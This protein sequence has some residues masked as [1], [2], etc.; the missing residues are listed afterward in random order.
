MSTNIAHCTCHSLAGFE[1]DPGAAIGIV[2]VLSLV[3]G[4]AIVFVS[5]FMAHLVESAQELHRR[6]VLRHPWVIVFVSMAAL[7]GAFEYRGQTW[8][9]VLAAGGSLLG[10]AVMLRAGTSWFRWTVMPSAMIMLALAGGIR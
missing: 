2:A 6:G 8:G 3:A 5:L 1:F 9:I 10:Y 4:I 7:A